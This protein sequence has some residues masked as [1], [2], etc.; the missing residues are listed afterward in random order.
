MRVNIAGVWYDPNDTPIAVELTD[1]DKHMIANMPADHKKYIA[2]PDKLDFEE[3]VK[4]INLKD[5]TK[6]RAQFI[7]TN[8]SLGYETD[9]VYTL[10]IESNCSGITIMRKLDHEG[11]CVYSNIDRFLEN[12]TNVSKI[13]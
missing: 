12:W 7:G 11:L 9:R 8:G 13:K 4:N 3:V 6:I 5:M 10:H 2:Y 1:A